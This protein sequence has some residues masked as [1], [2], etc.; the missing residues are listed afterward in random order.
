MEGGEQ[1][2]STDTIHQIRDKNYAND[3]R[4]SSTLTSC[5]LLSHAGCLATVV[6][7]NIPPPAWFAAVGLECD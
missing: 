3:W 5:L 2:A 4:H 1:L 7:L 6:P